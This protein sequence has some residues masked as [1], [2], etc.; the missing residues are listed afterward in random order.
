MAGV[1]VELEAGEALETMRALQ[2]ALLDLTPAM[3]AGAEALL[4]FLY[5]RFDTETGPDGVQMVVPPGA[6]GPVMVFTVLFGLGAAMMLGAALL[7]LPAAAK[8]V[9]TVLAVASCDVVRFTLPLTVVPIASLPRPVPATQRRPLTS[10][11]VRPEPRLRRLTR[12]SP[13]PPLLPKA[14]SRPVF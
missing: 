11:R 5:D 8:L 3:A 14:S 1:A 9:L 6:L 10:T 13:L 7:R 4:V 12:V 2:G